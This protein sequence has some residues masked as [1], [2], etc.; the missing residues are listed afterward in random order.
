MAPVDGTLSSLGDILYSPRSG[1]G[2]GSSLFIKTATL[3]RHALIIASGGDGYIH[4]GVL[5]LTIEHIDVGRR[6]RRSC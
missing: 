5:S 1:G 4:A 2:S 6:L 3:D